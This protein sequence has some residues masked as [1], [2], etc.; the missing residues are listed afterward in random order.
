ML[1]NVAR[2]P[3]EQLFS[4]FNPQLEPGDEVREGTEE[5]IEC[6][7]LFVTI[8]IHVSNGFVTIYIHVSNGF[9]TIYIHVSNGF[10]TIYIHVSN[11]FVISNGFLLFLICLLLFIF[12]GFW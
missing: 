2:K 1:A 4:Q 12:L 3:L 11:G 7:L 5:S 8:Y 10:V 9:V 6:V